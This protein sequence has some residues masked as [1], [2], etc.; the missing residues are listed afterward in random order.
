MF[1]CY[2]YIYTSN[3]WVVFLIKPTVVIKASLPVTS[4]LYVSHAMTRPYPI[5]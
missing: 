5:L 1:G 2:C 4:P 3:W